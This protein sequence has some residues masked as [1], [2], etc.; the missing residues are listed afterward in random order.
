MNTVF[1]SRSYS[2]GRPV[3]KIICQYSRDFERISALKG[4]IRRLLVIDFAAQILVANGK[5]K[6]QTTLS[7]YD[8]ANRI[9]F[10]YLPHG[11]HLPAAW[12]PLGCHFGNSLLCCRITGGLLI[13]TMLLTRR[14]GYI[15]RVVDVNSFHY[16][17][18]LSRSVTNS[19]GPHAYPLSATTHLLA[20]LL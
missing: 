18:M 16:G 12:L 8:R 10:T 15:S 13:R 20:Y 5:Q 9:P 19:W 17:H 2:L 4:H 7:L 11:C 3:R 6:H 14:S 1:H